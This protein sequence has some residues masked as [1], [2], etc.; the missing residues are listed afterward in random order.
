MSREDFFCT[1]GEELVETAF[2]GSLPAFIAA[3]TRHRA[4]RPEE[5]DEL[6]RMIDE[7]R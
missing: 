1:Q 5:L 2:S 4:L 3:F 7:A 6:Q